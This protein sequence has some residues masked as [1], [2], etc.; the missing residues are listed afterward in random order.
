MSLAISDVCAVANAFAVDFEKSVNKMKIP[1]DQDL[2]L[3]NLGLSSKQQ[4]DIILHLKSQKL[5]SE[6]GSVIQ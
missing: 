3:H 2:L 5:I 1:S 6:D 4:L